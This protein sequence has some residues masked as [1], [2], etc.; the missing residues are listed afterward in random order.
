MVTTDVEELAD[1][2]R[3]WNT[4]IT[5]LSPG[6]FR[7]VRES[8]RVGN[9][10][11]YREYFN[12]G[13]LM[14]GCS[15]PGYCMIG[16]STN[17]GPGA[18]WCGQILGAH[19]FACVVHD[20]ELEFTTP[21]ESTHVVML[22]PERRM[23]RLLERRT[24]ASNTIDGHSVTVDPRHG[25]QFVRL[26]GR[27]MDRH[28]AQPELLRNPFVENVYE[29]QILDTL[30]HC[31]NGNAA[32]ESRCTPGRRW[33]IFSSAL[34][35]LDATE[36]PVSMAEWSR[37]V[38]VCERT[39]EYAFK[40]TIGVTPRSF[41][42][43]RQLQGTHRELIAAIPGSGA[44]VTEIASRWGFTELGRYS[45]EYRRLF[46]QRPRDTMNM[47][48]RRPAQRLADFCTD[49]PYQAIAAQ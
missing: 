32:G 12:R 8:V 49:Q 15:P 23:R 28:L 13:T 7:G 5:Q 2:T 46:G 42:R 4:R 29:E 20:T 17:L 44:T 31:L 11:L 35:H 24:V 33:Q 27:A 37:A 22:I 25:N 39:M 1:A 19:R 26:F 6:P 38:G 21:D 45:V 47:A 14:R 41:T 3:P 48:R 10:V 43:N 18:N 36:K 34:E 9:L 16:T 40:A 30:A